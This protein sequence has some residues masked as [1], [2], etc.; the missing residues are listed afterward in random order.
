MEHGEFKIRETKVHTE[1]CKTN[2]TF[3]ELVP[4]LALLLPR[5][6]ESNVPCAY[7]PRALVRVNR[8]EKV[9]D[10]LVVF[11]LERKVRLGD[12]PR[13]R[14]AQLRAT[15]FFTYHLARPLYRRHIRRR[16]ILS[17]I[18]SQLSFLLLFAHLYLDVGLRRVNICDVEREHNLIGTLCPFAIGLFRHPVQRVTRCC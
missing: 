6:H 12:L 1:A 17:F 8:A 18:K 11:S 5:Q 7:L 3:L 13:L 10:Q 14:E 2:G 9:E 15:N 4:V 16:H